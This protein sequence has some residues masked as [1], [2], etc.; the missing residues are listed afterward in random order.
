MSGVRYNY[1]DG[2]VERDAR[3]AYATLSMSEKKYALTTWHNKKADSPFSALH[4]IMDANDLLPS[5]GDI[6][7]EAEVEAWCV[8][9][10]KV[11]DRISMLI[12][13]NAKVSS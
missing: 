6:E 4:D 13:T 8:F 10:N 3:A 9:A 7:G 2:Q 12:R 1:N 11:S 5:M